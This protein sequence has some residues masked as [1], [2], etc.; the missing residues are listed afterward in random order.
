MRLNPH[1]FAYRP[2]SKLLKTDG[3]RRTTFK[4]SPVHAWDN[5][6]GVSGTEPERTARYRDLVYIQTGIGSCHSHRNRP[7]GLWHTRQ[8]IRRSRGASTP[9]RNTGVLQVEFQVLLVQHLYDHHKHENPS[10]FSILM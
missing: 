6:P 10:V 2:E 8:D 4:M 7:K 9:Y 1:T 5:G 3:A